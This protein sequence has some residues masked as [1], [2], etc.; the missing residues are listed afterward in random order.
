LIESAVIWSLGS[1]G[2][3][4]FLKSGVISKYDMYV[5]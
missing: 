2:N 4:V 3:N 1:D 5:E